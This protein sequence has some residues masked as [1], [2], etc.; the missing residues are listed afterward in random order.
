MNVKSAYA[1][2]LSLSTNPLLY[3]LS[4]IND[5]GFEIACQVPPG[6]QDIIHQAQSP[7]FITAAAAAF[8]AST[9][10]LDYNPLFAMFSLPF[11]GRRPLFSSLEKEEV[12]H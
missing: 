3:N 7:E 4:K 2:L 1:H 10:V 6:P 5:S 12:K 8:P 9:H 11:P